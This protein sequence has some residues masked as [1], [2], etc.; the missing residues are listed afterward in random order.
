MSILLVSECAAY[1]SPGRAGKPDRGFYDIVRA[2]DS[3]RP[4][5]V[6][7]HVERARALAPHIEAC[8]DQIELERRLTGS[9]LDALCA[10]G[11]VGLLLPP[12][13]ARAGPDPARPP[14]PRPRARRALRRRHVPPP[15]PPLARRRGG[16]S[17][18]LRH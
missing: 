16:G 11:M 2:M 18:H 4:G 3:G 6:N 15:P 12:S 9:V 1:P 14:P 5:L 17:R 8:A 10:A 7:E 13:R